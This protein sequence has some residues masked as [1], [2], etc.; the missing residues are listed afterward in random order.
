ML[1]HLLQKFMF[2][3]LVKNAAVRLMMALR[4]GVLMPSTFLSSDFWVLLLHFFLSKMKIKSIV[5][6]SD[7]NLNNNYHFVSESFLEQRQN[8]RVFSVM[9][10]HASMTV[11]DNV[12]REYHLK[13][14]CIN[15]RWRKRKHSS[16]HYRSN[17]IIRHMILIKSRGGFTFFS[18]SFFSFVI[19]IYNL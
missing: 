14:K 19:F 9:V 11:K 8:R 1:A 12:D 15:W 7:Q 6:K 17:R 5:D 18:F 16:R 4:R 10:P 3:L 2:R 13:I